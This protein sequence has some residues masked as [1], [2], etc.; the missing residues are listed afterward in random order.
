[1][2]QQMYNVGKIVNTHG[3][4]G[5]VKVIR[6]TDF[7]DRFQPG[8]P[9]YWVKD[10][11]KPEKL[12]VSGHREHKGFDLLTFEGLP[13]IND[14]ERLKG[15]ILQIREEQLSDLEE[16]EYYF[17]EIIGCRVFLMDGTELGEVKEILTPGANDV[18]VVEREGK[19]DVLIPYIDDVVKE[20]YIEEGRIVIDPI[21]GL[22]D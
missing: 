12:I 21:E 15:G 11:G 20:V 10:G 3:I 9:L 6:I 16:G 5:E 18:W 8:A 17:H 1:M 14:V 19:S 4:K 7:D 13:T 22:L 2:E